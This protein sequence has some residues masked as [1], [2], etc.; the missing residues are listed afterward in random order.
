M[1][2]PIPSAATPTDA[3]TTSAAFIDDALGRAQANFAAMLDLDLSKQTRSMSQAWFIHHTTIVILLENLRRLDPE[4][5]DRL[6]PWALGPDGIFTDSYAG[7]LAYEWRQQITAGEPL[8]PI[9]PDAT[10]VS[11]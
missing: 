8:S 3:G 6:V 9:A 7:E 11:L 2:T 10:E 5:A 4:L 1:S